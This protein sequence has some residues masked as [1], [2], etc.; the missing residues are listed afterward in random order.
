L[1]RCIGCILLLK[2]LPN[3]VEN[4]Q[5]CALNIDGLGKLDWVLWVVSGV[6]SGNRRSIKRGASTATLGLTAWGIAPGIM[7]RVRDAISE[8]EVK[9]CPETLS[10]RMEWP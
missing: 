2:I 10:M 8:V 4:Q 5:T 9:R 7:L 1:Q 3:M 6:G